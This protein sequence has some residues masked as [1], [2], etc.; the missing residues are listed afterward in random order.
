MFGFVCFSLAFVPF[1]SGLEVVC[2][3]L[4]EIFLSFSISLIILRTCV[5]HVWLLWQG[6][7]SG[8]LSWL[9]S[10]SILSPHPLHVIGVG[11]EG[12]S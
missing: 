3:F 2:F 4:R 8:V 1:F 6:T 11:L 12:V 7:S 5:L 9:G 10:G